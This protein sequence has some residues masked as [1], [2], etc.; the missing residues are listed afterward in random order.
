MH[1][2]GKISSALQTTFVSL[3]YRNFRY[4]WF[5]QCISLMGTW[6]QRTAQVWL[7]YTITKSPLLVGLLGVCQFTPMLCLTLFAGVF[8]DRFPK[9]NILILTQSVF[10]MLGFT[11]TILVYLGVIRYWQILIITMLFGI[12]QTVDMPARQS[13][14]IELIGKKDI[15]NGI[16]L[17]S[18]IF[19]LA[20]IVG[21]A[22]SGIV[23]ARF[24]IVICFLA[25]ALSYIAVIVGLCLI[26]TE[27]N[28]P[29]RARRH[30]VQEIVEG[31]RYI[32]SNETLVAN[33]LIM[34]VVCTFA[35][36]NDVII[37]I[38]AKTVL[39]QGAGAYTSLMSAAGVG[40]FIGAIVMATIAKYGIK[41][42]LFLF[43]A[44]AT[45]CLQVLMIFARNYYLALLM[46]ALIGFVNMSFLNLCNSIFQVNTSAEFRGRVMSVY[47]FLNQGSTPIGNFYSGAVMDH[48]S[49]ISGFPV[50]GA[51]SLLLLIPVF[52]YKR[53]T[54]TSWL[55]GTPMSRWRPIFCKSNKTE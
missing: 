27:D 25:D 1:I 33:A 16:S 12:S 23:M 50:C 7:V 18:T 39:H 21:P 17:N 5:G 36:N 24:G 20:K 46:I 48:F 3:K 32:K 55:A 40:S 10:M 11:T 13:F 22:I 9:R 53:K 38:F 47:A 43:D 30:V 6:M 35:F 8:V 52:A 45:S 42:D 37:P 28:I 29:Q 31:L 14:F 51:A 41:K 54:I 4:F 26:R 34:A 44:V 2:N 49:G 15:M 19:N